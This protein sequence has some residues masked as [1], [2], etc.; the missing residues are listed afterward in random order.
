MSEQL[1]KIIFLS[2][3]SD[4]ETLVSTGRLDRGDRVLLYDS[5]YDY[6]IAYTEPAVPVKGISAGGVDIAPDAQGKVNIPIS[7]GSDLG[8]VKV[9]GSGLSINASSGV[10]SISAAS[11]STIENK[12]SAYQPIV[13]TNL[14]KAVME[15]LGNNS[16]TWS[17]TYKQNAKN[18]LGITD[19]ATIEILDIE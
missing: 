7:S 16:L 1:K 9:S 13:P 3:Q 5:S 12:N 15:G 14:D 6:R 4:F 18:T 10:V 11:S 2:S 17:A 8:L 19:G